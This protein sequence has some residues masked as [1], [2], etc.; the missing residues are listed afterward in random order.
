MLRAAHDGFTLI[1]II[2]AVTIMGILAALVVPNITSYMSKARKQATKT[3]LNTVQNAIHSF[4][5]DV[6]AYPAALNELK[7]PPADEKLARRWEGPYLTREPLDGW[8][9]ELVYNLHPKGTQPPYELYSWGPH[10]EG[11]PQE[12]WIYAQEE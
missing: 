5:A 4:H 11:S 10:G 12:E 6:S 9:N 8:K 7:T 1:E 3:T 2:I